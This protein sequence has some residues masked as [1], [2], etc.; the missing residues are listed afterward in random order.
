MISLI[1]PF[2]A[3]NAVKLILN[4]PSTARHWRV[5]RNTSGLFTDADSPDLIYAGDDRVI[6]DSAGLENDTLYFYRV[7]YWI[8]SAWDDMAPV[9]SVTPALLFTDV[10]V[11][12]LSLVRDRLDSGLNALLAQGAL[13]H[14]AGVMPVLTASPQIEG[15]TFPI[16]TVHLSSDR[17]D[18]RG[19]GDFVNDM[20]EMSGWYTQTQLQIVSWCLNSDERKA[21]RKAV[22]SVLLANLDFFDSAGLS[23]IDISQSDTE[24]FDTWNTPM[25]M[26]HTAFTCIHIAAVQEPL[27]PLLANVP[28][29][30]VFYEAP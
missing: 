21:V 15:T 6:L 8:N 2:I 28:I 3:G 11:D 27:I 26:T 9:R 30:P 22:K 7:F 4:P 24:N 20:I 13:T 5:L 1:T 29:F 19:I 17:T 12:P 16:V 18:D 10:S 14:H 23:Q 25:Y